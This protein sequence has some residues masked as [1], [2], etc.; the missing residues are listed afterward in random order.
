MTAQAETRPLSFTAA[1]ARLKRLEKFAWWMDAAF[2]IPG[3]QVRVG[4]DGL[5]GLLPVGGDIV[6][7]LVSFYLPIMAL[8]LGVRWR[9]FALMCINVIADMLLGAVP[10]AG[11]VADVLYR[12]NLMNFQLLK[13][14]LQY[15][16][17]IGCD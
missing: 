11:D 17:V 16:G 7:A 5:F 12:C 15:Q 3:T 14:D 2:R 10:L 9:T 4:L 8:T 1:E 13:A 6:K